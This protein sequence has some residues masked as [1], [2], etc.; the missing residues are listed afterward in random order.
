M[1]RWLCWL[2]SCCYNR[3]D[4]F[5]VTTV[6]TVRPRKK[7]SARSQV[8]ALASRPNSTRAHAHY[9]VELWLLIKRKLWPITLKVITVQNF[10]CCLVD[11]LCSKSRSFIVGTSR[12]GCYITFHCQHSVG[13]PI[14]LWASLLRFVCLSWIFV[15]FMDWMNCW[16]GHVRLEF[17]VND[18]S[19]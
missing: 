8:A 6:T 15:S 13:Q 2:W 9:L 5:T 4:R 12:V 7:E 19:N 14:I 18:V 17:G 3:S 11:M 16:C 10:L 1:L